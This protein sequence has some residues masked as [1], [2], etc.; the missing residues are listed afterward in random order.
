MLK[1]QLKRG[2]LAANRKN[3]LNDATKF[4]VV[5]AYKTARTNLMFSVAA[6]ERKAIVVTSCSPS[7]GKSITCVNTALAFAQTGSKVLIIDADLRKP[8]VHSLLRLS[9]TNGLS[10]VLGRFSD[11]EDSITRDVA[12]NLDVMIAGTIPPN[13]AE[14]LGS[15]LMEEILKLLQD[16]YDYILIDSPPL[17][18]VSDSLVMRNAIAGYLL[19]V[20]EGYTTHPDLANALQSI[21]LAEGK[22]LGFMKVGCSIKGA[23]YYKKYDYSYEY[24]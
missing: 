11:L 7:E 4:T 5:E 10:T 17:L 14:L 16:H 2:S 22:V 21:R 18:V 24:K 20:R 19:V 8:T 12:P 23:G 1:K 15:P 6:S 9:G 3:V 13:P